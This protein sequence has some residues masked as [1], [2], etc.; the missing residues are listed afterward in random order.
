LG[1]DL[2]SFQERTA[3]LAT[4]GDDLLVQPLVMHDGQLVIGSGARISV[5][6]DGPGRAGVTGAAGAATNART[7]LVSR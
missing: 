2:A 6:I 3:R 7:L 1:Q 4:D 5:E